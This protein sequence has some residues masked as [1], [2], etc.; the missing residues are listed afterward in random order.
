[1]W[2]L[3]AASTAALS[4]TVMKKHSLSG[5]SAQSFGASADSAASVVVTDGSGSYSTAI[6]SAVSLAS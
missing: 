5:H 1:V 2:P 6:R 3:K 4:P